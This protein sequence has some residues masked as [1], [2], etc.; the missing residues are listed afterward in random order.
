MADQ[1]SNISDTM[2]KTEFLFVFAD[3]GVGSCTRKSNL[4]RSV[5]ATCTENNKVAF[6]EKISLSLFGPETS[7]AEHLFEMAGA[8]LYHI[9][10]TSATSRSC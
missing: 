7:Y 4:C 3:M 5:L 9:P 8:L 6:E 10:S 2:Q 1:F